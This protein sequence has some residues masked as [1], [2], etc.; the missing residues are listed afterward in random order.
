MAGRRTEARRI[1][2]ELTARAEATPVPP[3]CMAF[4]WIGLG[5]R[6][7]ALHWLEEAYRT[8]DSYLGHI[9]VAPIVDGLRSEPR[10]IALLRRVGLESTP[11]AS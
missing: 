7:Q 4:I 11:G 6:D 5:N 3:T 8:R 9:K 2:A 1:L 10:F